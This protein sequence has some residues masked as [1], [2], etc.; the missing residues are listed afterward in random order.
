MTHGE[1][2][3][4]VDKINKHN[5]YYWHKSVINVFWVLSHSTCQIEHN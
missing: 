1:L 4:P 3:T 5:H 2:T